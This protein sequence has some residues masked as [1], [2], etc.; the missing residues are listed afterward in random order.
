MARVDF[1]EKTPIG[2]ELYVVNFKGT[3]LEIRVSRETNSVQIGWTSG[4]ATTKAM[5]SNR[6]DIFTVLEAFQAATKFAYKKQYE[7][8]RERKRAWR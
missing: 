3:R 6:F 4:Y 2:D 7:L 8:D 5:K 1:I